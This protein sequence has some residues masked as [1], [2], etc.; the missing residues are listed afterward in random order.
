MQIV[1]FKSN[2]LF[3]PLT[4]QINYE[5]Q[6]NHDTTFENSYQLTTGIN[7]WVQT[8]GKIFVKTYLKAITDFS[9]YVEFPN[10]WSFY[11]TEG[12]V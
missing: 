5:G 6:A 11:P 12:E 9:Q 8:A 4:L 10:M 3:V 1:F 7:N 2:A